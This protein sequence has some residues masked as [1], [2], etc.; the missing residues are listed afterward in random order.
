MEFNTENIFK[1]GV[2]QRR[3]YRDNMTD[4]ESDIILI[5]V[6]SRKAK[7]FHGYYPM[8]IPEMLEWVESKSKGD[9]TV[10]SLN[11]CYTCDI[12]DFEVDR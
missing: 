2:I 11:S 3:G 6:S 7:R 5:H 10:D 8:L 4:C 1:H 12:D 9:I